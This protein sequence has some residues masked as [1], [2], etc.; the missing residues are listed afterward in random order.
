M[1]LDEVR[2]YWDEQADCFDD[3]PD[4]G[5]GDPKVRET[6]R[7]LLQRVLPA[8]PARVADLGAG[9]G[10][11]AVLLAQQGYAVDGLDLSPRMVARAMAK[12]RGAGVG[13]NIQIGDAQLP[14]L[15]GQTYDAVLVRHLLWALPDQG[16]AVRGWFD[17]LKPG[18]R[19]VLVEGFWS[20]GGGLHAGEVEGLL[21]PF[22]TGLITE[23][24][25]DADLWGAPVHDERFMVVAST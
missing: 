24:L 2:R 18:G 15:P 12:A 10:T 21:A 1:D 9:T 5:L 17:L 11:L 25:T 8:A 20:T 19:L 7:R 6:W 13:V 3:Q 16:A 14:A 22:C 23:G 4:H